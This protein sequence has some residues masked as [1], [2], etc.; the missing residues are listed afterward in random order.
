MRYL[1]LTRVCLPAQAAG[2]ND[3]DDAA[4]GDGKELT[5][6]Q[7][8]K[9]KKKQKEKEKKAGGGAE[10]VEAE[11]PAET[12]AAKG[13]PVKVSIPSQSYITEERGRL[14]CYKAD[15]ADHARWPR[16]KHCKSPMR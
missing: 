2:N 8:K 7:K 4:D 5:A 9:L 1:P 16:D 12:P 13:K 3:G 10:G 15:H 14:I 6:A 11:A